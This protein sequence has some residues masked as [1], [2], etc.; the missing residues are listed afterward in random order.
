MDTMTKNPFRI[1]KTDNSA[2]CQ[3]MS[4]LVIKRTKKLIPEIKRMFVPVLG[5]SY[6]TP[7]VK[8]SMTDIREKDTPV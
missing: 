2:L 5:K 6:F 3:Y 4:V 8:Q 1:M 7:K